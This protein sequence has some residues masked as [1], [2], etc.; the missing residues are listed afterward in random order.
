MEAQGCLVNW[1]LFRQFQ[2]DNKNMFAARILPI[3]LPVL[4]NNTNTTEIVRL[5]SDWD[6]HDSKDT[7]AP[8]VFQ[9]FIRNLARLVIVDELGENIANAQL[10]VPYLWQDRHEQLVRDNK[11]IWFDDINTSVIESRDEIIITA[12]EAA[13]IELTSEFRAR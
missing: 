10:L 11:S 5:L 6:F 1:G 8:A 12:L 2:R 4:E 3:V 13:V 7:A 9:V